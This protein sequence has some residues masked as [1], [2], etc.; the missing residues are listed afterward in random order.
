MKDDLKQPEFV[1]EENNHPSDFKFSIRSLFDG[2]LIG[3]ILIIDQLPF[4]MFLAFWGVVYIGNRYH[5]ENIARQT[6]SLSA[7]VKDLRA[8][9][10]ITSRDLMQLSREQEVLRLIRARGLG[11]QEPVRP[12]YKIKR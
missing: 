8:Q 9:S 10:L 6:E 4:I 11:L 7:Q 5:A 1:Q 12:P 3:S 2:K